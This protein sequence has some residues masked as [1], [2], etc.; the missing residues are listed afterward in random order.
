[1][2]RTVL[3]AYQ[4]TTALSD[5]C[6]GALL[7]VAP[8]F[9]LRLMGVH[10]PANA[11]PY[12]GY[13]G[14]FVL[15]VGLSCAYGAYLIHVGACVERIEMVWLLTAISRAAVALYLVPGIFSGVFEPA[16][17]GVV[18]F[19]GIC[20]VVQGIGLRGKWLHYAR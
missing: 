9:T 1:M 11:M 8:A 16:W 2:K 15:S 18:L 7:Y 12:I 5:T 10:A 14:A 4:W 6:T 3:L 13:I 19:D 20:V 17:A